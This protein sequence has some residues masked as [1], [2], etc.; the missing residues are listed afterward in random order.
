MPPDVKRSCLRD[1]RSACQQD[2][3]TDEK[4]G[5]ETKEKDEESTSQEQDGDGEGQK[6]RRQKN[7]GEGEA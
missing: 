1:K 5:P 3:H 2:Q 6:D 7:K 4:A